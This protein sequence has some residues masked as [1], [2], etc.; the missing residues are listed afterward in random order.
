MTK[1]NKFTFSIQTLVYR[2]KTNINLL[3]NEDIQRSF[4]GRGYQQVGSY[5][6]INSSMIEAKCHIYS[7]PYRF[8]YLP[9]VNNSFPGGMFHT[10]R[11]LTMNDEHQFFQL[12]SQDLPFLEILYIRNNKPQKDK[13]YLSTTLITFPHLKFLNLKLA[14]VDY[15]EQ[16]LFEK[17]THLPSLLDLRI[18]YE[19]LK[20]IT[21]NFIIDTTCFNFSKVK[22]LYLDGSF[23]HPDV[24]YHYFP[25]I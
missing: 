4:I 1:L 19:S 16:F 21:N 15:A 10:V 6:N 9:D 12:T 24:F 14:H 5:I 2:C 7:L 18:N 25:L 11:R 20:M 17:M 13:Q 23:L 3:S 22:D 8:E